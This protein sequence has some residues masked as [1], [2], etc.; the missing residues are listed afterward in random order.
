MCISNYTSILTVTVDCTLLN[1]DET[2][3]TAVTGCTWNTGNSECDG[4]TA[5]EYDNIFTALM[6]GRQ[7]CN[8]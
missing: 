6:N 4:G 5:G 8:V 2:T 3:C 7:M 1:A